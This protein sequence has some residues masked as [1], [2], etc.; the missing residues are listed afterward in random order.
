MTESTAAVLCVGEALIDVVSRGSGSR[1]YVGGSPLNVACG[2]ARLGH[3]TSFASW[4]ADDDRGRRIAGHAADHGLLVVAGSDGAERTS[5]ALARLDADGQASYEF[6]LDWQLPPMASTESSGHL[7]LG[8][9]GATLPPGA[10]DVLALARQLHGRATVSYDPNVRPAIMGAA[11]D[12][13]G[14]IEELVGLSDAVKASSEDLEW[15]YPG[16]PPVEAAAR[17]LARGPALVV[18]TRGAVGSLTWFATEPA[19]RESAAQRVPV[20]DTVG[21]GDSFMAGLL[22]GLLDAG[23][24]G[25]PDAGDRLRQAGWA[26]VGPAIDRAIQTS[27]I[28][29][30]HSGAYSPTRAELPGEQV[31]GLR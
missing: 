5:T 2:L 9:I 29:V 25:R 23:L 12:V 26:V 10:D 22:S 13:L 31:G 1:E 30:T 19:P 21:A 17:W 7:H 6:D 14:R 16:V 4:W 3:P 27:A 20:V 18:V 11:A 28:T 24:L 8:S 15:L